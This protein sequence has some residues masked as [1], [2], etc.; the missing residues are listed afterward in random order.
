M[1]TNLGLFMSISILSQIGVYKQNGRQKSML[2]H[3]PEMGDTRNFE[4]E[5]IQA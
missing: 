3:H 1:Q 4:T 5:V 2:S